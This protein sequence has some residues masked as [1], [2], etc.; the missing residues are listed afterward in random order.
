MGTTLTVAYHID[1]QLCVVHV[2]DSRAYLFRRDHLQQITHD[3]T[4]TAE[5]V[6]RGELRPDE[7]SRHR[8]RHVITN[9]VGGPEAGV[10]VEAHALELRPADRIVLCSDGLTEM[11]PRDAIVATLKENPEPEAACQS[12]IAQANDAGGTDNITVIVADF[13]GSTR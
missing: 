13:D 11:V 6:R 3:H 5:M 8:L 4:L 12:L 10:E 7:V 9:V 1:R 2:G